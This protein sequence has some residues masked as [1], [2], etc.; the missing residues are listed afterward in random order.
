[1]LNEMT[2]VRT[3]TVADLETLMSFIRKK[4]AFD[5]DIGSFSGELRASTDILRD[6]MFG[7]QAKASALFLEQPGAGVSGFALYYFRFSSFAGRPSLWLDDLFVE[8]SERGRGGGRQLMRAVVEAAQQARCTHLG[9]TA[10][11]RNSKGVAFYRAIGA[12]PVGQNGHSITW[13][14]PV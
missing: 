9:W 6:T 10:D 12:A 14:L 1:M 7:A 4:E 2:T 11:E 5:R 8:P 13:Q 3:A